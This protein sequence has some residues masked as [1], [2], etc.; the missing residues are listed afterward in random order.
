MKAVFCVVIALC[1]PILASADVIKCTF[2]EPSL[3][4][5]YAFGGQMLTITHLDEGRDSQISKVSIQIMGPGQFELWDEQH[6]VLLR[7]SLNYKGRDGRSSTSYPYTAD[8][9]G[10]GA[11]GRNLRGGCTSNF[12]KSM[13]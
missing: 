9:P 2:H 4:L 1:A 12:Q 6:K 13:Q 3:S 11:E 5:Q 8:L 7:L 10:Y